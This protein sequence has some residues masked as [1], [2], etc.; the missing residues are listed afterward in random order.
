MNAV[1]SGGDRPTMWVDRNYAKLCWT[2]AQYY[3]DTMRFA[4]A[5]HHIGCTDRSA[6]AIMGFNSPEWAIAFFGGILNNQVNTGIYITNTAE[7]CLYQATHAESEIICVETAEHLKRFTVNL[8]KY[9]RV[10]AFVVWGENA[11]PE[12]VSGPR[13]FLWKDFMQLGH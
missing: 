6:V 10:K 8:D 1:R 7:A 9:D 12:G 2:W 3:T 4:K 11:L 5:C 13:F